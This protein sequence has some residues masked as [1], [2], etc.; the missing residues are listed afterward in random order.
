MMRCA[1]IFLAAVLLGGCW[2]APVKSPPPPAAHQDEHW[3]QK[4]PVT[5]E[6]RLRIPNASESNGDGSL[7]TFRIH[8]VKKGE[9]LSVIA[10]KYN[11]SVRDILKWNEVRNPN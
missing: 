6:M 4:D 3:P 1:I 2:S 8:T 10:H 11:V 9:G 7:P 5:G